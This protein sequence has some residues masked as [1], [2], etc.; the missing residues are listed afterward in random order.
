MILSENSCIGRGGQGAVYKLWDAHLGRNI[1]VKVIKG[2]AMQEAVFLS[3]LKHQALP[4]VIQ[5]YFENDITYILMEFIEGE[6]LTEIINKQ[7]RIKKEQVIEWG[8]EILNVMQYLHNYSPPLI[9]GDL[10]TDNLMIQCDGQIRLIDFGAV[11]ESRDFKLERLKKSYVTRG[12]AAPEQY[13]MINGNLA[14]IRCDIYS[15]GMV[16]FAMLTGENPSKPPYGRLLIKMHKPELHGQLRAIIE[17][18]TQDNPRSRYQS[19]EECARELKQCQNTDK[20]RIK[21]SKGYYLWYHCMIMISC[22]ASLY[23]IERAMI[24]KIESSIFLLVLGGFI[25]LFGSV[26]RKCF[27]TKIKAEF[28]IKTLVNVFLSE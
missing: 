11:H 3:K 14:D 9:Y 17:C 5:A 6:T 15:F 27:L 18:C 20:K 1:A 21:M 2:N 16:L 4:S 10:K 23:G 12:F 26:Y 28:G 24:N 7:G 25:C 22:L 13:Q 19:C 8:I